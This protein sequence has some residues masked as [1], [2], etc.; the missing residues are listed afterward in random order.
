[1]EVGSREQFE[2]MNRFIDEKRIKPGVDWRLFAFEEANISLKRRGRR[3]SI[4]WR[5]RPLGRT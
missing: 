4:C 2:E 1:M 5:R 3:M